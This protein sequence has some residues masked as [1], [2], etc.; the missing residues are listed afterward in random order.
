MVQTHEHGERRVG[1]AYASTYLGE[2]M[3]RAMKLLDQV[4]RFPDSEGSEREYLRL[5]LIEIVERVNA[6]VKREI[7][8]IKAREG[9][10]AEE[11]TRLEE[12]RQRAQELVGVAS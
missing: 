12:S 3:D 10:A 11:R 5:R 1:G 2:L 6:L 8:E 7:A 9:R 4:Q